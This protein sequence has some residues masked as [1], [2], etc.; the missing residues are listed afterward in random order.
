MSTVLWTNYFTFP[1]L[2]HSETW[3]NFNAINRFYT[4]VVFS[5]LYLFLKSAEVS[6]FTWIVLL[7]DS[8]CSVMRNHFN[9]MPPFPVKI[10]VM[11]ADF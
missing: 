8:F 4:A 5:Q 7:Q 9:S 6:F 11:I 10:L 1:P 2:N 3:K